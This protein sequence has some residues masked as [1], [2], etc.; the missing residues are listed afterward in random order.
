MLP[1]GQINPDL[2][3]VNAEASTFIRAFDRQ[4]K[5][6]AAICHAPWLLIET[7]VAKGRKSPPTLDHAPI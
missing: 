6:I 2:L 3:R 1:G 7:G 5:V 4:N